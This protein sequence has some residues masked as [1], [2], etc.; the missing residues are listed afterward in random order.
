MRDKLTGFGGVNSQHPSF[1]DYKLS[2]CFNPILVKI[3]TVLVKRKLLVKV[4]TVNTLKGFRVNAALKSV[5]EDDAIRDGE[6]GAFAPSDC[7]TPCLTLRPSITCL[8][9][10]TGFLY[11]SWRPISCSSSRVLPLADGR[12]ALCPLM[13]FSQAILHQ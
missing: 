2:Q 11:P 3:N 12:G 10:A 13:G 1:Y 9:H 5:T 4:K 6:Q 8:A 7:H